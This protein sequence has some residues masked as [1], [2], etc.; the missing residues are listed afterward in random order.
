MKQTR[1]FTLNKSPSMDHLPTAPQTTSRFVPKKCPLIEFPTSPQL[2]LGEEMLHFGHPHHPLSQLDLP[3]HFTCS[4]CKEFGA[5]L[6]FTCQKCDFQLH[7]FCALA[8]P[9]LKGHPFHSQHQLVFY[10]K[11]GDHRFIT[12]FAL[13]ICLHNS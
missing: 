7:D 5:G 12:Y 1:S 2:I 8:P 9:T 11:S 3:D 6:R 13:L 4:G 10:S